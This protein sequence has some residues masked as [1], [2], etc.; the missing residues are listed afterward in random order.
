MFVSTAE[1]QVQL[2][3][4]CNYL[5][6]GNEWI[7]VSGL[8]LS[9][10]GMIKGPVFWNAHS[11]GLCCGHSTLFFKGKT[12]CFLSC[13]VFYHRNPRGD[14]TL[15]R[16]LRSE[17][18]N[19]WCCCRAKTPTSLRHGSW[20]AM[21][22]GKV[23]ATFTDMAQQL[24]SG[25]S[26]HPPVLVMKAL[27]PCCN[28]FREKGFCS[29]RTGLSVEVFNYSLCLLGL[30]WVLL[31]QLDQE[32]ENRFRDLLCL[33]LNICHKNSHCV[34]WF[35]ESIFY[36]FSSSRVPENLQLPGRH[37]DRERGVILPRYDERYRERIWR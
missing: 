18:T 10:W 36:L 5:P 19:V 37:T 35:N 21:C 26:H 22:R 34:I 25:F 3:D 7:T 9:T 14:L 24:D 6:M 20:S 30:V 33:L 8:E 32:I 29:Q 11:L 31:W 15:R 23:G 27:P 17:P 12:R 2:I 1:K 16:N 4:D 13:T 28:K